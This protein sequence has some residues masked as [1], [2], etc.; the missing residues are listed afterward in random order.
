MSQKR[1]WCV[2]LKCNTDNYIYASLLYDT[3]ETGYERLVGGPYQTIDIPKLPGYCM[4][5]R[6]KDGEIRYNKFASRL[7]ENQIISGDV[8]IVREDL[9]PMTWGEMKEVSGEIDDLAYWHKQK[10]A[11]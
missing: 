2:I 5:I 3:S 10:K 6:T 1:E 4:L 11:Q 7:F 9:Q 8:F